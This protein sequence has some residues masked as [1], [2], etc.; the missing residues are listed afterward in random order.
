MCLRSQQAGANGNIHGSEDNDT[1][2]TGAVDHHND[3]ADR[4][5]GDDE[6]AAT[7][8]VRPARNVT[9]DEG[10]AEAAVRACVCLCRI[11]VH[12]QPDK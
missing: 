3:D 10:K 7:V 11:A 5:R 12:R 1:V 8:G 4:E 2:A 6:E 9:A